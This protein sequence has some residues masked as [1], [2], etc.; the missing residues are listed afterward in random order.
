MR[1]SSAVLPGR[2]LRG[3]QSVTAKHTKLVVV[4]GVQQPIGAQFGHRRPQGGGKT[5]AQRIERAINA[6]QRATR[7]SVQRWKTPQLAFHERNAGLD[8][9]VASHNTRHLKT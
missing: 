7:E 9:T 5:G 3:A 1:F 4:G 2:L 6:I 8:S